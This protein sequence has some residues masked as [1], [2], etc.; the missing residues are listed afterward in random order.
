MSGLVI[1]IISIVVSLFI[2]SKIKLKYKFLV[3][4]SSSVNAT[5]TVE[6][7]ATNNPIKVYPN[8]TTNK[9]IIVSKD[10]RILFLFFLLLKQIP[11]LNLLLIN[12]NYEQH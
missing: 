9:L 3:I 2:F 1:F 10:I 6:E 5:L 7:I 11:Q 4:I 8:P 12:S